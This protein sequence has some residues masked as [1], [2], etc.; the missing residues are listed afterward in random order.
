MVVMKI[1]RREKLAG[2]VGGKVPRKDEKCDFSSQQMEIVEMK[3]VEVN[4]RY[5]L[6]ERVLRKTAWQA[7]VMAQKQDQ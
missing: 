2:V 7:S 6:E 3:T 1:A 5:F 4:R